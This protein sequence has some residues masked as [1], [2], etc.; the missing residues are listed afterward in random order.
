MNRSRLVIKLLALAI[1]VFL[2]VSIVSSVFATGPTGASPLDPL[3][4]PTDS[5][6]IA[7]HTT[8]WFYFDYV[9][10]RISFARLTMRA[11][12]NV[13]VNTSGNPGLEFG[14]YTP[15]QGRDWVR[16]PSITPVG[17]GTP[18]YDALTDFV[19]HDLYWSGGFNTSGRYLIA[20]TNRSSSAMRFRLTVTGDTVTLYPTPTFTPTP[21]LPV[22]FTVTPIPTATL[23]GKLVFQTM[24][25]GTIY[26]VNGDGSNLIAV[27]RGIDPAW[28]PD[29]KQ[30]AF[31]RWDATNP[32]LYIA[33]A[34]G[35]NERVIFGG[36]NIRSPQWS[37]DAKFIAFTQDK[38]GGDGKPVWKL[39]L[40]E[41][42][43]G[44]LTEPQC[45]TLCYVPSWNPD[46]TALA[47]TDPGV[48][49]QAT[50][51]REGPAWRILGPTGYYWDTA[52]NA[53]MPILHLPP[54]Q[55]S[56]WSPDGKRIVYVE[57]A[58]DR[59][60]L[61]A[62]KADGSFS[63]GI[64][65]QDPIL[66]IFYGVRVN[67]VAPTWSPDSQQ[68]LYLADRNGKWEFFVTDPNGQNIRQV[69]KS[70]TDRVALRFDFQNER[71]MDW[72]K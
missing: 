58:H 54:I 14:I 9:T 32:G 1:A 6:T 26:T 55:S 46:G 17:R 7:P 70:V 56:K 44:K 40:V 35:S 13:I 8:L 64:T 43:T 39:G 69:L 21:V 11:N 63:T 23:Q 30:I 65:N 57:R 59:W 3:M 22:P 45:S 52:K 51:V 24:T 36:T 72:T 4:V 10:E 60:E 62:V 2:G 15:E 66:Y 18:Y 31:A 38:T 42:A 12:A 53:P 68:I 27:S 5:Q 20:L 50:N 25:G 33:N 49:I 61:K 48:G 16:D 19:V 47:F 28:S 34:D 29:G 71:M 37:P 67:S 41:I